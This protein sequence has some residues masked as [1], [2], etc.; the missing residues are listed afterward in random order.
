MHFKNAL[1]IAIYAVFGAFFT[2]FLAKLRIQNNS[3]IIFCQVVIKF[4]SE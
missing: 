1:N 2:Q 3:D 4:V